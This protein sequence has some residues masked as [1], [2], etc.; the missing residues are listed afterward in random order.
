MSPNPPAGD[1]K[2]F[3]SPV[4]WRPVEP[5]VNK[6]RRIVP[7]FFN[8]LWERARYSLFERDDA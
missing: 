7:I 8:R 2:R 1:G 6:T 4:T 3:V 5:I